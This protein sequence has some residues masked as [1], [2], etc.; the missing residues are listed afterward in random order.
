MFQIS[1]VYIADML[2]AL[3]SLSKSDLSLQN[4]P[5]LISLSYSTR[6]FGNAT[7]EDREILPVKDAANRS[8]LR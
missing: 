7:A 2:P 5:Y 1:R 6:P 4:Y 3:V 8:L